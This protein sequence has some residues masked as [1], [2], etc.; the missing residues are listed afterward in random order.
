MKISV[1]SSVF[2]QMSLRESLAFLKS[3]GVGQLELGVGGYPGKAHADAQVL[4]KD[5]DKRKA[6]A[7]TFGEAGMA[8]SALAVH[9]NSVTPDKKAAA[10]FEADFRAAATLCGQLGVE[11]LVTFSGCPGSDR[12]AKRPAWVT[13]SWPPEHADALAYQWE[14]VLIPYWRD[15]C[16][17]ASDAGVGKI[18]LEM[19]PGFCVY[20]PSTLL[21]LRAAAGPLIGAN[22]DPSHLIWQGMDIVEVIREL[23]GAIH[24]FH[25]KDTALDPRNVR[26][27]GV[28]DNGHYADVGGRAWTFRTMGYG[29][30]ELEWKRIFSALRVAGYDGTV[31]IEHEDPLMSVTEGLTKAIEFVKGVIFVESPLE[32]FWA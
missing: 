6:L 4:A 24:Y 25:A 11:T 5:A 22:L 3:R 20:N 18:A 28:L 14:E 12:D 26:V 29:L 9:G 21:R 2:G 10:A 32:M 30:S 7:D 27:N 31:S 1:V 15:A 17:R 13:C 8:I 16:P 23:K 19:H